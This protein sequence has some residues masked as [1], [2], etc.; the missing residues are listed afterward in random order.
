MSENKNQNK[1]MTSIARRINADF[2]FKK[3]FSMLFLDIVLIGLIAAGYLYWCVDQIPG[4]YESFFKL[5]Y[6]GDS[7]ESFCLEVMSTNEK[8]YSYR[9][10]D[11]ADYV[12]LP[13]AVFWGV[14]LISL[15]MSL[16]YTG[17]IRRKLKPLNDLAIK[18][19]QISS[20]PLDSSSLEHLEQAIAGVSPEAS[21]ASIHTGDKELQSIEVALNNLLY[22]MKE[23]EK[24]QTRF[25]SDA[26]HELRTPISVI[27]GY[28]N[29]LDRWGKEDEAVLSES[30]E[31]L[32]MESE[33]MKELIEQLLFLARGDSGRNTLKKTEFDL[34]EIVQ[35]VWEESIMIDENHRYVFS[36]AGTEDNTDVAPIMMY[37]DVAMIKQSLRIFV[38]NAAKYSD[39]GDTIIFRVKSEGERVAYEVQDEG[40]GMQE[41]DVAHIFERFYR[42]DEARNGETGG[43]GLGLSI[44]KWIVDAHM[45]SITVLSRPDFGTRFTVSFSNSQVEDKMV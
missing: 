13:L 44:A 18:A 42:S 22:R 27:Q 11:F 40:V 32:K 23:S 16:F 31:A 45:G 39:K 30:I 33:H 38:Q 4:G 24:K 7:Y 19:E 8:I 35:E 12:M 1:K 14:Q 43:S 15:A 36:N 28:V 41:K 6:S 34:V 21:E 26:S 3:F 9:V 5:Q 29:M 37:G 17:E 20:I 2:W 10:C 25:V